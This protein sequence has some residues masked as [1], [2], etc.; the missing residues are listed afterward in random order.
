MPSV[1]I[2]TIDLLFHE[3]E[4]LIACFLVRKGDAVILIEC[5]AGSTLPGLTKG[6]A[7]HGLTPQDVTHVLVTHIHFDHAGAA[8]WLAQ[9]GAHVFV[10][11][12]GYK[13]LLDPSR[14]WDSA[15]RIYGQDAM[16][17]LWGEILPINESSLTELHDGDVIAIEGLEFLAL[18]TPGH[19][20]HHHAFVLEDVIFTG[21]VAA[22]C[23]PG[24]T[25]IR[26]P[27]PPP[28][29]HLEKW[30]NSLER[31]RQQDPKTLYLTHF[32]P[33]GEPQ[34]FLNAVETQLVSITEFLESEWKQQ[35]EERDIVAAYYPWMRDRA[36]AE[37]LDERGLSR[38]E[39][40][41]SGDGNVRG[42][43]RY[44]RKKAEQ[45]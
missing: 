31:L 30:L 40:M 10:H 41:A 42:I 3:Q 45:A 35:K 8:G 6:L 1:E 11:H 25:H 38:Y 9:Q 18:D 23:Q 33:F 21:D 27:S 36:R 29:F 19:A 24:F 34:T 43:L 4:E 12:L 37:G 17:Q 2:H 39:M 7:A 16:A 13:H 44:L 20:N 15:S 14:L 5:G 28:E 26:V 22:T 32:G